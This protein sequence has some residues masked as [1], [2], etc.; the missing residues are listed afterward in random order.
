MCKEKKPMI[1]VLT[2]FS[3]RDRNASDAALKLGIKL[4]LDLI[5]LHAYTQRYSPGIMHPLEDASYLSSI[6]KHFELEKER[7]QKQLQDM[8]KSAFRPNIESYGSDGALS[9][10]V[11][12]LLEQEDI[13]L[14]VMGGRP[15]KN[16][17]YLFC[18]EIDEI[19]YTTQRPVLVVPEQHALNV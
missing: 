1:L 12:D 19:L 2:E 4:G 14:I 15:L 18:T 7:L 16:N 10:G 5:L 3:K 13:V 9:Q 8:E 17:D 6:E 11:C